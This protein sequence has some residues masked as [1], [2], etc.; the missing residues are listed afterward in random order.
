MSVIK[1]F[2]LRSRRTLF[3]SS[4]SV[5][6]LVAG[7]LGWSGLAQAGT[8]QPGSQL[9]LLPEHY[10]LLENGVVV[11]TLETGEDL[12]L[13]ADQYLILQDGLLLVTDE[14]AQAA[15]DTMPVMGSVR[16]EFL[17]DLMLVRSPDGTIVKSTNELPL[18]TGEGRAPRVFE[19]VDLER[20]ELAQNTDSPASQTVEADSIDLPSVSVSG[21]SLIGLSI[22]GGLTMRSTAQGSETETSDNEG[23]GSSATPP[24]IVNFWQSTSNGGTVPE[25]ASVVL[26]GTDGDDFF[27]YSAASTGAESPLVSFGESATVTVNAGNGSNY[28]SALDYTGGG[29][30]ATFTYNGGDGIDQIAVTDYFGYW[31]NNSITLNMGNGTNS[32]SAGTDAGYS[33]DFAY[34]GGTGTDTIVVSGGAFR[35]DQATIDLGDD[36]VVDTITFNG[37]FGASA[38]SAPVVQNFD[39]NDGDQILLPTGVT[40]STSEITPDGLNLIFE[41]TGVGVHV[42]IFEGLGPSGTNPT[43]ATALVTQLIT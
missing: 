1:K 36:S 8:E 23:S 41:D 27:G 13:N 4:A 34:N 40:A 35:T 21:M 26:N 30:S 5:F 33:A 18:W 43:T 17:N 20:Y 29:V 12:S 3:K 37:T 10:E 19:Q 15:M 16:S 25:M 42:V 9:M 14:H 24:P 32:L 38:S 22:A 31:S 28:L 11:F 39:V 7:A 6:G 2:D